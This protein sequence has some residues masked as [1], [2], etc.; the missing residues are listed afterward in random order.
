MSAARSLLFLALGLSVG[1]FLN[2]VAYRLPRGQSLLR[3]RSHCPHCN[4]G[5]AL[6]D[7]V[8]L[9]SF[10]W[11]RGRCRYCGAPISWRYPVLELVTALYFLSAGTTIPAP[12][13]LVRYLVLGSIFLVAAAIDL[14]TYTLPDS[15]TLGGAALAA[16]LPPGPRPAYLLGGLVGWGLLLVVAVVSR[17]GM[18][19]GDVKLGL[20]IGTFVAWPTVLVALFL[21]FL[22]GAVAGIG[23]VVTKKKK[24]SDP[25]PFGPFLA[26]GALVAGL[27]GHEFIQWYLTFFWS[28]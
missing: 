8:P 14:D 27:W 13:L 19:G 17:G 1:S 12:G 22:L 6:R 11:L 25:V 4:H 3:P 24:R 20:T 9:L 10:L 16:M 21:A 7:L 2:V 15:L 28:Y 23:L 18:G 5:L 26:F